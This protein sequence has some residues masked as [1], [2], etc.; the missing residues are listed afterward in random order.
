MYST[1]MNGGNLAKKLSPDIFLLFPWE[2][3]EEGWSR[4]S[5][6]A[7]N[8]HTHTH[9]HT[10]TIYIVSSRTDLITVLKTK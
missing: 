5:G 8:T 10:H 4:V 2:T 6:T 3:G 7:K 9:T 1:H